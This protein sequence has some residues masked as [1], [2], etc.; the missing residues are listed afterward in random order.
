MLWKFVWFFLL[1]GH[2]APGYSITIS[3]DL[4]CFL[5]HGHY[6]QVEHYHWTVYSS[7][8]YKRFRKNLTEVIL[9]LV[10][11][12]SSLIG[13]SLND[14]LFLQYTEESTYPKQ[15]APS[16]HNNIKGTFANHILQPYHKLQSSIFFTSISFTS[17]YWPKQAMTTDFIRIEILLTC[18]SRSLRQTEGLLL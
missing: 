8:Y 12:P 13:Q 3:L 1:L 10:N 16:W 2:V 9:Y 15:S 14:S 5:P 17:K 11:W 18:E 7:S 6:S 4:L